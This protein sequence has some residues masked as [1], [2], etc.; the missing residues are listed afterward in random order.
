MVDFASLIHPAHYFIV[1]GT[2]GLWI[3]NGSLANDRSHRRTR[4]AQDQRPAPP[5]LAD[6]PGQ[7]NGGSSE[8]QL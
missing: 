5:T 8:F 4:A 3:E 6:K 1:V 7:R 2:T